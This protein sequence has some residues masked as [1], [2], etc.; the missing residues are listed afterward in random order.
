MKATV[1]IAA[2]NAERSVAQ[3]LASALAQH[4]MSAGDWEVLVVN[5]G[6]TDRTLAVLE[7]FRERIRVLDQP[8]DGLARACNAGLAAARGEHLLR[9]DADDL[10][11]PDALLVMTGC[12][13]RDPDAGCAYSDRIEILPSG[14]QVRISMEPF[15]VFRTI[16]CGIMFRTALAR[17]VGGYEDLVFEEHDFLI[18]YLRANPTRVYVPQA[19]YRYARH[20]SSLTARADYWE[21][22]WQ[23]MRVKWGEAELARWNYQD[24]YQPV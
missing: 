6:S 10:L 24:V 20:P 4:G 14:Q 9:L 7:D 11:D 15:N 1:L 22:G 21:R 16:A 2:Y 23:E 12:L 18:R 13:D 8:H 5:D 19:L 3:A 17:A